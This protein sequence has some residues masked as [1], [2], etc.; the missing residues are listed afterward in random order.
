[1]TANVIGS[2]KLGTENVNQQ[3]LEIDRTVNAVR[4]ER[5]HHQ[6]KAKTSGDWKSR[7]VNSSK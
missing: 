5:C 7:H 4:S 2:V 3:E 6:N 1:V